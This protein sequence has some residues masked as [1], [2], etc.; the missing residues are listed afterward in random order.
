MFVPLFSV[1]L[2]AVPT[3]LDTKFAVPLT[4]RFEPGACVMAPLVR[5]TVRLHAV[6]WPRANDCVSVIVRLPLPV[7]KIEPETVVEFRIRFHPV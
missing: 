7:T 5:H 1:I 4:V 2:P 6:I 3:P